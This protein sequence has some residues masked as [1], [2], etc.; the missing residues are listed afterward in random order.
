MAQIDIKE[1]VVK[2]FDGTPNTATLAGATSDGN[3]TY[4]ALDKHCGSDVITVTHLLGTGTGTLSVTVTNREIVVQLAKTDGTCTSTAHDVAALINADANAKLLVTA[5]DGG[6]GA[7]LC[8]AVAATDLTGQ[9]SLEIKIGEGNLTY[10]EKRPVEFKRDRGSLDTVKNADEEPMDVK[11]DA[12]WEWLRADT[13]AA[14]TIE[15]ALKNRGE[16]SDWLTTAD[17]TCQPYCVDIEIWNAAGC[18]VDDDEIILLEEFYYESLDHDLREGT[19]S[20]S[21]RC[22]RTEAEQRRVANAVIA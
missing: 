22:N 12:T 10:S 17:D 2:L 16:A 15:D 5:V 11:F 4:T 3:V 13:G 9:H 14:V 8:K 18:S 1:A 19:I 7:G 21:G 20:C 6:T